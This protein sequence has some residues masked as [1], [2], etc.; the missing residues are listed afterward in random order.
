MPRTYKSE[1]VKRRNL[2]LGIIMANTYSYACKDYPEMEACPAHF[3]TET[4]AELWKVIE[5]HAAEAHGENPSE[6]SDGDRAFL[7]DLIK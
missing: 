2:Y 3:T 7:A 5:L 4:K 6:W 1:H